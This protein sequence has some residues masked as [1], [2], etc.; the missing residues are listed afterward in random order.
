MTIG[1]PDI[2]GLL[3]NTAYYV[4]VLDENTFQLVDDEAEA[5]QA[6][7]IELDP[8][9]AHG[10]DH[11]FAEPSAS[12]ISVTSSLSAKNKVKTKGGTGSEPKIKDYLTKAEMAP[13]GFMTAFAFLSNRNAKSFSSKEQI[14]DSKAGHKPNSWSLGMGVGVNVFEH[15]VTTNIGKTAIL[16]SQEDVQLSATASEKIQLFVEGQSYSDKGGKKIS[17]AGAIGVYDNNVETIINGDGTDGRRNRCRGRHHHSIGI[18]LSQAHR[19][20]PRALAALP[21]PQRQDVAQQGHRQHP[22]RQA[23]WRHRQALQHLRRH[24]G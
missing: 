8:D 19:R 1:S 15:D 3:D 24:Q 22:G 5:Y 9:T 16:Q 18:G 7:P 20:L 10:S 4:V 6:E 14:Q 21:V 23:V 12:G 11:Y 17:I 2:N 13:V